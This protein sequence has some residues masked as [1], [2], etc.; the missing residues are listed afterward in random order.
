MNKRCI[1]NENTRIYVPIN[2]QARRRERAG[3]IILLLGAI[4]DIA[5]T[6]GSQTLNEEFYKLN[7]R[8]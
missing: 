3:D 5:S 8:L 4:P 7:N 1:L 2:R 6:R